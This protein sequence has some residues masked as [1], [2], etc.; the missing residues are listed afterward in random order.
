MS[1]IQVKFRTAWNQSQWEAGSE[2]TSFSSQSHKASKP[3]SSKCGACTLPSLGWETTALSPWPSLFLITWL[4]SVVSLLRTVL[5]YSHTSLPRSPEASSNTHHRSTNA[6]LP[7][8]GYRC[9]WSA[10]ELILTDS[11]F[12]L[13]LYLLPSNKRWVWASAFP[14]LLLICFGNCCLFRFHSN[15]T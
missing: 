3:H 1:K 5:I 4:I 13:S 11:P 7:N 12:H 6:K 15:Q 9:P 8:R 10:T 2:L 14:P